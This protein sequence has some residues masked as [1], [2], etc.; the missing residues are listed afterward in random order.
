MVETV[1]PQVFHN[2]V[3]ET[4][5]ISARRTEPTVTHEAAPVSALNTD[6]A[7]K[8]RFNLAQSLKEAANR[9][10]A[11]KAGFADELPLR[12]AH[13]ER[14]AAP[15]AAPIHFEVSKEEPVKDARVKSIAEKLGFMNFDE[16]EFDTPSFMKKNERPPESQV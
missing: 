5:A 16:D 4:P 11:K 2:D 6:T 7:G 15:A 10:E 13:V 1:R 9:Y 14:E 12:S 3:L 8:P